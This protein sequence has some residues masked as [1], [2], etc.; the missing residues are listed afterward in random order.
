MSDNQKQ[1]V[2][3]NPKKTEKQ[4]IIEAALRLLDFQDRTAAEL[5]EKLEKKGFDSNRVSEAVEYL[6]DSGL[7][8]DRRYAELF[9]Q[10]RFEAGKG[11][12]WIK[13]RLASKG[14]SRDIIEESM[15]QILEEVDERM[16]CLQ[17]ALSVCS[18]DDDFEI[19]EDGDIVPV[20]E[21]EPVRY[22]YRK[23]AEDE[24]DRSVI[25]K[26]HE[27]AKASLTRKL[28]TAGFPPGMVFDAVKKIDKL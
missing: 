25:Y 24:R 10:G 7:V 27:K 17:K 28:I 26:E 9:A 3:D 20:E 5:Q 18:L 21:G 8:D 2:S 23:V 13:N 15:S 14:I 11:R 1:R 19:T 6:K 12:T 16:L 22:F 4:K